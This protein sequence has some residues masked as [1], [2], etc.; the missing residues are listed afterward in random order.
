MFEQLKGKTVLVTGGAG[1]VGSHLARKLLENGA[2]V[3]VLDNLS[4]GSESNIADLRVHKNFV[5]IKGDANILADIE[6]VFAKHKVD[7]VFHYAAKV[8]VL[9]TIEHPLDVMKDIDGVRNVLEMSRQHGVKKV[10]FSSS[11]EVYGDPVEFPEREDGHLN[12]KMPYAVV[13]LV[14]EKYL[15][16]YNQIYGLKTCSLRF[17]NI[18]GPRQDSSAYG[19]VVGIFIKQ[20]LAGE[21]LSVFGDGTQTR[22]FVYIDDNINASILAL[23]SAET[24]GQVVN[25]G[26]GRPMTVLDLAESIIREVGS[27]GPEVKFLPMRSGG[28]IRH[29]FPDVGKMRKLLHYQPKYTIEKGLRETINWYKQL[30]KDK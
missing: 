21:P 23:L 10:V 14:G 7:F 5:F 24:D 15:E 9:R 13:K 19:F 22:D 4:T 16:L 29:R 18:Y 6:G 25:I 20:A 2:R 12:P 26:T 8:G 28:E 30:R 17:F 11:S 1:F 27:Q 3:I